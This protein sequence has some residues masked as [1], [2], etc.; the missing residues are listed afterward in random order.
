MSNDVACSLIKMLPIISTLIAVLSICIAGVFYIQNKRYKSETE[1][2]NRKLRHKIYELA[3]LKK[4]G[5]QV[6]HSIK[7]EK[8]VDIITKSL[9]Q[10]INYTA[11]AYMVFDQGKILLKI[12]LNDSVSRVFI[13]DI[14][15]R[16][17][18]SLEALTNES[19]KESR[20]EETTIGSIEN[21][22]NNIIKSFFNI[23]LVINGDIVGVLTVA[24]TKEGFYKDEEMTLLYKVIRQAS[25]EVEK[26]EGVVRKEQEKINALVS[27]M[28]EGVIMVDTLNNIV[29]A[30]PAAKK[31]LGVNKK[32]MS[33]F[34]I[35]ETLGRS[36]GLEKKIEESL[37]SGNIST[38]NSVKIRNRSYQIVVAPVGTG[39]N[40]KT[41]TLGSAILLHDI[42]PEVEAIKMRKDFTEMMVHKLRTPLDGIKKMSEVMILDKNMTNNTKM[43][44]EYIFMIGENASKMLG[45]VDELFDIARIELNKIELHKKTGD[46]ENFIK[47]QISKFDKGVFSAKIYLEFGVLEEELN[48]L[49]FDDDR[50]AQVLHTML[51]QSIKNNEV[52]SDILISVSVK[53]NKE[54]LPLTSNSLVIEACV[55]KPSNKKQ[56]D[57]VD[58]IT[59]SEVFTHWQYKN[60]K[61]INFILAKRITEAH[62][63]SVGGFLSSKRGV[64]LFFTLEI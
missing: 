52:D 3:I 29:V 5:E 21:Q 44:K 38:T 19:I 51:S 37:V 48:G 20:I 32:N 23:P 53:N 24:N 15:K 11:T 12:N 54:V 56:R 1:E 58:K 40:L 8:V 59:Q 55:K 27:S 31:A 50:V 13:E 42:T 60:K 16:M 14:K 6:G 30:N 28:T 45:L 4:L 39:R 62:G 49:M 64:V 26:L 47:S 25:K 36:F 18:E 2:K 41:S 22:G 7:I 61:N 35:T 33:F 63:G 10:F 57:V 34:D 9:P 43:H 17:I 46:F